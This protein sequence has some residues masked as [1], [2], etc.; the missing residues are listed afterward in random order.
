MNYAFALRCEL[1]DRARK[2]AEAGGLPHCV[3]Y[4]ETQVVCF[5][6]HPDQSRHGNF[7]PTSYRAIVSNPDWRKRLVK[8]HSHGGARFPL[9]TTADGGNLTLYELDALLMNIFL[10]SGRLKE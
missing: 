10:Q 5:T 4:G 3:G 9:A 6:P 8:V 7:L 2:Y 1:S